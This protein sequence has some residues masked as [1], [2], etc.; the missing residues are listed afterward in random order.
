MILKLFQNSKMAF[1]KLRETLMEKN[2][3]K[4][5]FLLMCDLRENIFYEK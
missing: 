2:L 4:N 3:F 1:N 5:A